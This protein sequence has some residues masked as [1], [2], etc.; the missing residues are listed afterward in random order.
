MLNLLER[1][2]DM[3]QKT[4]DIAG[5]YLAYLNLKKMPQDTIRAFEEKFLADFPDY[6]PVRM[7]LVQKALSM[8]DADRAVPSGY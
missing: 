1:M 4:P 6:A 8:Q 2:L 7:D 3:P 5:V